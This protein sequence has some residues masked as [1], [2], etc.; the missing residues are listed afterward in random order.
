MEFITNNKGGSKLCFEGFMYT[1]KTTTGRQIQ[2]QCSNRRAYNCK[3]CLYTSLEKENPHVTKPHSHDPDFKAIEV[4]K[5]KAEM[6]AKAKTSREKPAQILSG[7]LAEMSEDI[8]GAVGNLDSLKRNIRNVQ[9]GARP[10]EPKTLSELTIE[11]EWA[12]TATGQ[13]FLIHDSGPGSNQRVIVFASSEGIRHLATKG[14][15]FMDGTFDTAPKLFTQLY[16]I[17]AKLGESAVSCAY[18]QL[19][20]SFSHMMSLNVNQI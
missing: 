19:F 9:R 3:A 1:Q 2:W 4:A 20:T 8:R 17:R 5:S 10:K 15:W 12:Q 6:K 11:D 14:D 13:Q 18:V 16:V 7:Q